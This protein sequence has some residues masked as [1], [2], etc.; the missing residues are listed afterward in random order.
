MTLHTLSVHRAEFKDSEPNHNGD[1]Y[2]SPLCGEKL[3]Y[4]DGI[5]ANPAEVTCEECLAIG[6][7]EAP[8]WKGM[9]EPLEHMDPLTIR[10]ELP[11]ED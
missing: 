5:T 6:D 9:G 7:P 2:P 10:R 3:S 4:G 8:A 1:V 11:S